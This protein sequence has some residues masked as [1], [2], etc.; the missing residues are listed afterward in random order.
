[1]ARLENTFGATISIID[2]VSSLAIFTGLQV[3]DASLDGI[4]KGEIDLTHYGSGVFFEIG[5]ASRADGGSFSMTIN[6]DVEDF[7]NVVSEFTKTSKST[8]LYTYPIAP[9][10][11]N[12]TN[13]TLSFDGFITSYSQTLPAT[14]GI[15]VSMVYRVADNLAFTDETA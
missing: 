12:T 8:I 5:E 4:T 14:G 7:G 10:S 11:V 13:A 9:G 2:T 3:K 6:M 1:M 15:D